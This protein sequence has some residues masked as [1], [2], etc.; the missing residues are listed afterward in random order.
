M[1]HKRTFR[2]VAVV[3]AA[4]L[5]LG[6]FAAVSAQAAGVTTPTAA[7][8]TLGA[9]TR[10]SLSTWTEPVTI[11]MTGT[12]FAAGQTVS[13]VETSTGTSTAVNAV[14]MYTLVAADVASATSAT[15]TT[16]ITYSAAT[17]TNA[18]ETAAL[19]T[20]ILTPTIGGF[21]GAV[22]GAITIPGNPNLQAT[23][24]STTTGTTAT[25]IAGPA[26]SVTITNFNPA[27][28]VYFT[29]ANGMTVAGTAPA[30]TSGTVAPSASFSVATPVA[31]T[32]VV[33]GYTIVSGATSATATDTVTITAAGSLPGTTFAAATVLG[34]PGI[35]T[36]TTATDS[37]FAVTASSALPA[38]TVANFLLQETDA[39]GAALTS[40]FKP[41]TISTT[42]G[43][44]TVGGS[45]LGTV[46][47]AGGYAIGTPSGQMTFA[48]LNNG[49]A[50]V[51]KVIVSVN[52][53]A[54]KT[55][56][57]TFS[58]AASKIVLTVVNPVVAVGTAST[59]LAAA[60]SITANTNALEVQEFDVN[61][62][63]LPLS[64]GTVTV[65]PSSVLMATAGTPSVAV[66]TSPV[67]FLG[68][69]VSGTALSATVAGVSVNGL[70]AGT[71]TFTASDSVGALT[72]APVTV[73]V[74]SGV[75]TSVAF[76]TDAI[77]YASGAVG[78]LTTTLSD[79]AG[80]VP[81][82]TY[83]VLSYAGA[84]SSYALS[85]GTGNLPGASITVNNSGIYTNAF[86]A[87]VS[88]GI[89]VI[90]ATPATTA[91]T[92]RPAT[93]T[94]ASNAT[95]SIKEAIDAAKAA[96][97]A[98]VAAGLSADAA[99]AAG[100]AATVQA[101][102]AVAAVASLMIQVKALFIRFA[103]ITKLLVRLIH[104]AR[105]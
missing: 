9:V 90:S 54:T 57:V 53:V 72:S 16:T 71:L 50:G 33:T 99:T 80:T 37:A 52:G 104:K 70:A 81:A 20:Q 105:A 64:T 62:N 13:V 86:N 51:A 61:G 98:A 49:Q 43:T 82:G 34:A 24:A 97:A 23:V 88:D 94:V 84:S 63:L 95:A 68:G 12:G 87:P 73:R 8:Q 92:V 101:A 36:P 48:L 45:G 91:I 30:A 93:F 46:S 44:L 14:P 40:G 26:N 78:T 47:A 5:A 77:S 69:K 55:Y 1:S 39:N 17:A 27:N 41:L 35:A 29:I 103:A 60:S 42:L 10:T 38:V 11:S 79:A 65:T 58:G 6:G 32:I 7:T 76:T 25:Q 96:T 74:S 59:L 28:S 22:S 66:G 85:A 18:G 56:S 31:G 75:P 15:F 19:G 21:V 4:A 83:L 102:A 100:K 2:R 67:N 89:V 3:V